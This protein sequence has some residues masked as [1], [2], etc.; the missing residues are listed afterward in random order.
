MKKYSPIDKSKYSTPNFWGQTIGTIVAIEHR[1]PF[2]L[3]IYLDSEDSWKL[4]IK[5]WYLTALR[6]DLYKLGVGARV[7]FEFYRMFNETRFERPYIHEACWYLIG[8]D[9]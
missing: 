8:W 1:F 5:M 9:K 4:K 7:Y 2:T 6:F 3:T